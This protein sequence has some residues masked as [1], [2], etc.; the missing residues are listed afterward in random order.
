[1][2]ILSEFCFLLLCVCLVVL[3]GVVSELHGNTLSEYFLRALRCFYML[4]PTANLAPDSAIALRV[5]INFR[6]EILEL[7]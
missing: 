6:L 7:P 5:L 4:V 1:M 3:G 2:E